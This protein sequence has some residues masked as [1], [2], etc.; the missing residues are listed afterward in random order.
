MWDLTFEDHQLSYQGE[1]RKKVY[2]LLI[3]VPCWKHID[4][5]ALWVSR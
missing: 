4:G 2:A 1:G 3:D 5:D